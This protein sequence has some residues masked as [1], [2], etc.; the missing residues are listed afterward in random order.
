MRQWICHE[1]RAAKDGGEKQ[2]R[3]ATGPANL[4]RWESTTRLLHFIQSR[5]PNLRP[6]HSVEYPSSGGNVTL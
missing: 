6:V 1:K 4:A 3:A 2:E 5:I